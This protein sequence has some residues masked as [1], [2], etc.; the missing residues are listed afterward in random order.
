MGGVPLAMP[1]PSNDPTT[2]LPAAPSTAQAGRDPLGSLLAVF[3]GK[4]LR[5]S[6]AVHAHLYRCRIEGDG[7][8]DGPTKT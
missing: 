4:W 6:L 7:E 5:G 3:R 1:A 8:G 2:L